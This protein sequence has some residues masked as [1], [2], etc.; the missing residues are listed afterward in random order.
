MRSHFLWFTG[1]AAVGAAAV[2]S[3]WH[4]GLAAPAGRFAD[5]PAGK[6]SATNV[7]V[8]LVLAVDISYSMD[9]EEQALQ[10]EGYVAGLTSPEF[11]NAL[12]GGMHG[13]IAVTYFE[14][15]GAA[16]Q[17]VVVPWRLV[18]GPGTAKSFSDEIMAAPYRRAYRTSISGAL[19]FAAPLFHESGYRGIRRVID[20]SG[21][22]TNNQGPP[23]VIVRDEVLAKGFT[24]NGLPIM[25]RRP[26]VGSLD[27]DNLDVYYEDCVIGGP[28]AFVIPIRDRSQFKDATRTKLVLEVAG[29]MPKSDPRE[30]LMPAAA[31][32]PR[33]SC[34]IGER[35][36]Q[37]RW[38]GRDLN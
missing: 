3:A 14:W 27:I 25:L 34:T 15:A 26:N 2:L 10:R 18:D 9:P 24:I 16:E 32:A 7:D 6:M 36:W 33:V 29:V 31:D 28:A 12:R 8:E 13:R 35:M 37:Q 1:A 21:D 22:G 30:R 17:R 38:G 5:M 20:V 11:L 19:N 4:G 23:I